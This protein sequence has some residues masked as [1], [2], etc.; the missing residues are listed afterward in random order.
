MNVGKVY[1]YDGVSGKIITEKEIFSFSFYGIEKDFKDGELVAFRVGDKENKIAID[2]RPYVKV[3]LRT[4][5]KK[6]DFDSKND[7]K[8]ENQ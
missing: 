4:L 1:N 5:M 3:D 2:V 8:E 6:I 7:K